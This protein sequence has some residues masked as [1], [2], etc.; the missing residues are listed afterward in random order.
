MKKVGFFDFWMLP[1]AGAAYRR[2]LAKG[3]GGEGSE[4][5]KKNLT[6][7]DLKSVFKVFLGV[8]FFFE[9]KSGSDPRVMYLADFTR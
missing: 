9:K 4:V 6:K 3:G 7:I 5:R 1:R 2:R 8:N